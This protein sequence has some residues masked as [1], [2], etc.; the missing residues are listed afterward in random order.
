[1]QHS[2]RKLD[3]THRLALAALVI[4]SVCVVLAGTVL[5]IRFL[6]M[7]HSQPATKHLASTVA[8]GFP[9][10][11]NPAPDFTLSDQFGHSVTLASLRGREVVLAFIDSRCTTICPY[12]AQVMYEAKARLDAAAA[13]RVVLV[14]INANPNATSVAETQAWSIKHGMLHQWSFLTGSAQALEALYHAYNVPVEVGS[15]G[16]SI[17]DPATFIIDA[18]GRMRLSYETLDSSRPADIGDEEAGLLIGMRQW[19]PQPNAR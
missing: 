17:H 5:G 1:M 9:L 3:G 16:Q 15:N 7:G 13:S 6:V 2:E 10:S 18:Q 11:G 4:T 19:L 12:T 14:A 8:L